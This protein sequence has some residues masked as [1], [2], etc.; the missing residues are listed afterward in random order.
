MSAATQLA[1]AVLI[2]GRGSNM[3]AVAHACRSGAIAARIA[4]VIADRDGAAGIDAAR[5]LGLATAT[6]AHGGDGPAF[7]GALAAALERQGAHAVALAG[8]MRVLSPA[9]VGRYLGRMFNI[10]PSLL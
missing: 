3:L 1:L 9:F 7:E 8:F 2:S 4:L 5:G 10:H 6:L